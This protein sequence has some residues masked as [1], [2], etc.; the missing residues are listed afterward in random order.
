M[1]KP[2]H[3]LNMV[4]IFVLDLNLIVPVVATQRGDRNFNHSN[5]CDYS[6]LYLWSSG[7]CLEMCWTCRRSFTLSMGAT[8]VLEMAADTPPAMKSFAKATGSA[9][10]GN[11]APSWADMV[12]VRRAG[13][14]CEPRRRDRRPRPLPGPR[15][16]VRAAC[17]GR[18]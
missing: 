11:M 4:H 13:K 18:G 6:P 7:I 16:T 17:S 1:Q 3:C 10:A 12:T 15:I 5:H 14:Q 2:L 9:S 8:V